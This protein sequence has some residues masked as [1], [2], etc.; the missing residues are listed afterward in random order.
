M[1][2]AMGTHLAGTAAVVVVLLGAAGPTAHAEVTDIRASINATVTELV[3]GA[4]S[5]TDTSVESYPGTSLVL[6]LEVFAGLGNFSGGFSEDHGGRGL[7]TF[8]DPTLPTTTNPGEFGVESDCYSLREGLAYAVVSDATEVREISFV[9]AELG[10]EDDGQAHLVSS[11]VFVDGAVLIWGTDP[12][13][14]LSGLSAEF[15]ITVVQ[16]TGTNGQ[17]EVFDAFLAVEGLPRGDVRMDH[18]RLLTALLGRADLLLA[19]G[20]ASIAEIVADLEDVGVLHLVIM[21][22]QEISYDY[23]VT[24]GVD[25]TLRANV[26][27]RAVNLPDGTGVAAVFG[28]SFSELA[29]L[30]NPVLTQVSGQQ[31]QGA[32][33]RVIEDSSLLPGRRGLRSSGCGALGVELPL[34]GVLGIG[35]LCAFRQRR[36]SWR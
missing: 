20:G 35:T 8:T 32:V 24:P 23:Y 2:R 21:P 7:A 1:K 36:R 29:A 12:E 28:R 30:L 14:D 18:S 27:C 11:T 17:E 3:N 9:A 5:S 19:A 6:P 22:A 4:P 16:E 33:N 25:F 31:V 15:D 34:A 10:V 13:R 26:R